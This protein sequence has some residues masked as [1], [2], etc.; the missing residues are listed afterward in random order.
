MSRDVSVGFVVST[1]L[2]GTTPALAHPGHGPDGMSYTLLHY[3][4][5]PLHLTERGL[6]SL[7]VMLW[8]ASPGI[9]RWLKNRPW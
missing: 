4:T 3:L 7:A 2:L 6:V 1:L 9:V 8:I 5:D